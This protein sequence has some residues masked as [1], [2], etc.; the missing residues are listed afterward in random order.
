LAAQDWVRY[1]GVAFLVIS[2]GVLL[3]SINKKRRL[4]KDLKDSIL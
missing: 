4:E 1:T 3:Y 2:A